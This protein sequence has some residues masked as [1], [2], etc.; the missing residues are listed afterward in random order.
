MRLESASINQECSWIDSRKPFYNPKTVQN[1]SMA[2]STP[3]QPGVFAR[4]VLKP[5]NKPMTATQ[6]V[7][8][9]ESFGMK[10]RIKKDAVARDRVTAALR[11]GSNYFERNTENR[12][13]FQLTKAGRKKAEKE[14]K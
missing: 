2:E 1:R 3:L 12:H 11:N 10:L 7:E 6:I 14:Q 4:L 5:N 8:K 13:F 9:G